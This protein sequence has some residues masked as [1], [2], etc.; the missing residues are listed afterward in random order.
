MF[1]Q[2]K[3]AWDTIVQPILKRP[4][5]LQFSAL[6]FRQRKGETEVLLITSRGTGRWIMPKGWPIAGLSGAETARQEAWEEAGV[7]KA[8]I[9]QRSLGRF[10]YI[11]RLDNEVDTPCEAD[12][13]AIRVD[14]LIDSYPE[15]K[16]R[17]RRWVTPKQA[18]KMVQE[19]GL[20][21]ILR[22]F[23]PTKLKRT[24]S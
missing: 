8:T 22:S 6:C 16:M 1:Q 15:R 13:Y 3:K 18:A 19:P 10:S 23:D 7:K 17:K 12:V 5:Y 20:K 4:A 21:K 14:K 24:K 2:P 11:K 9:Y